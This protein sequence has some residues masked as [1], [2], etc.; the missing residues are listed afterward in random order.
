MVA[1]RFEP[2][3]QSRLRAV[4][5]ASSVAD[6]QAAAGHGRER[7]RDLDLRII[8]AAGPLIGVG[9][10]MVEDVFALRM[11]LH[12]GRRRR[13]RWPRRAFDQQMEP[14]TSRCA[15]RPNP[16]S[17]SA[18]RKAWVRNGLKRSPSRAV[19]SVAAGAG[20]AQASHCCGSTSASRSRRGRVISDG[21]QSQAV[22]HRGMI[23]API[24]DQCKAR[25]AAT[26]RQGTKPSKTIW[27]AQ[28]CRALALLRRPHGPAITGAPGRRNSVAAACGRSSTAIGQEIRPRVVEM[29]QRG[30]FVLLRRRAGRPIRGRRNA[31]SA[32]MPSGHRRVSR[33][34]LPQMGDDGRVEALERQRP[35]IAAARSRPTRSASRMSPSKA[36]LISQISGTRPSISVEKR[37]QR[38]DAVGRAAEAQ[39]ARARRGLVRHAAGC[40]G[41]AVEGRS[42]GTPRLRRRAIAARRIR[43]QSRPRW[44]RAPPTASSRSG[45]LRASC[46]PRWAIGAARQPVRSGARL[47]PF[48]RSRTAP[49]PR[50]RSRSAA[51]RRRWW[52][53]HGAPCRPAPPP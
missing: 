7:H 28:R 49:R 14:A 34:A 52:S 13:P 4:L 15:R 45:R 36:L 44:R 31:A 32:T 46:S 47:T 9:P 50:P 27:S 37:W 11:G 39:L 29:R 23:A 22:L 53:A 10:G 48:T 18:F 41:Q 51:P 21:M 25:R 40:A 20:L 1:Q 6:E 42:R 30:E 12:I 2:G 38:G 26:G 16:K 5:V 24:R 33:A 35:V 17:S 43:S 8:V 3:E 19:C